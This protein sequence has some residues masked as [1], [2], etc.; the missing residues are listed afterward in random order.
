MCTG[1]L[2][3]L[4]LIVDVTFADIILEAD[5]LTCVIMVL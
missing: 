2:P 4:S 3:D 1:C 5:I